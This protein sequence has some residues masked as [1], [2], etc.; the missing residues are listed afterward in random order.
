MHGLR[1]LSSPRIVFDD[2]AAGHPAQFLV[3]VF[4][5]TLQADI[6]NTGYTQDVC[7]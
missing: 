7:R 3:T 1:N 5:N 6:V 4:I 2:Y